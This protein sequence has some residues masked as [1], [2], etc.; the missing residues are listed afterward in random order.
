MIGRQVIIVLVVVAVAMV[1]V[2]C[3]QGSEGGGTPTAQAVPTP[4]PPGVDQQLRQSVQKLEQAASYRFSIK[5]AHHLTFESKPETWHYSG[6]GAYVRPDRIRWHL[7]GQA[8]VMF[9][10][11]SVGGETRCADTTGKP[12]ADCSLAWGGPL[13]G[14]SPYI[15]IAYLKNFGKVVASEAR[16]IDGQRHAYFAFTPEKSKVAALGRVY[17]ESMAKVIAVEGEV[18]V[19]QGSGLPRREV[20]K[21]K[22]ISQTG[23]EQTM[24]VTIDFSSYDQPVEINLPNKTGG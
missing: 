12:I 13:P 21:V 4:T 8:D 22:A 6:S 14:T 2:S 16:S 1:A 23:Q 7:E 9:D 20:V 11:V 5:G 24:D 10:V 15:V 17:A 19:D 3:Q 18:W